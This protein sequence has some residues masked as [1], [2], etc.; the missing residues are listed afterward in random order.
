MQE[1]GDFCRILHLDTSYFGVAARIYNKG[2]YR[3]LVKT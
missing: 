2:D 3:E 1:K